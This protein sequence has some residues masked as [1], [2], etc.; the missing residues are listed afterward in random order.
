MEG[1]P[2]R[3]VPRGGDGLDGRGSDPETSPNP[4]CWQ[5]ELAKE[6]RPAPR[7][8]VS[9]FFLRQTRLVGPRPGN[10]PESVPPAKPVRWEANDG[11]TRVPV[12][13]R[14]GRGGGR[15]DPGTCGGPGRADAASRPDYPGRGAR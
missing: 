9:F 12:G 13:R 8:P 7:G 10:A 1:A 11:A 3:P 2:I 15:G 6:T 5:D 14:D 4:A